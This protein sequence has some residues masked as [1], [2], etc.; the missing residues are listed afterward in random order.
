MSRDRKIK[1][2]ED[3]LKSRKYLSHSVME[4]DEIRLKMSE[5]GFFDECRF[6]SSWYL[7]NRKNCYQDTN[8]RKV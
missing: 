5:I 3:S 8:F 1:R 2:K 4:M 6:D 7:M